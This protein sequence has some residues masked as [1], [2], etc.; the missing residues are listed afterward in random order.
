MDIIINSLYSKKEIFLREL[1]S[2]AADALDKIRFLSLANET[3]LGTG[4]QRDLEIRISAD[5][6]A[7]TMTIRDKGV[8]M[9]KAELIANLGTVAKSGTAAFMEQMSQGADVNL[10]GQFG[11]GFYSVYLVADRVRVASKAAGDVQY[12]WDS[13]ADGTFTIAPDAR[14]DTLGRGTEITLFLKEDATEY[15][16]PAD[17]K[18]LIKK[19][20]EFITF[21]IYLATTKEET[22]EVPIEEV[23]DA[24][25]SPTPKPS[26]DDEDE[27]VE[28]EDDE[29]DAKP[30]TKSETRSVTSWEVINDQK[31]LWQRKPKDIADADYVGFYRTVTKAVDEPIS[32]SHFTAEGEVEFRSILYIPGAAPAG[33][34]DNYYS[35]Q[36]SLRLYVRKVLISDE[37]EELLPRYLSFIKGIVDSDDLPLNVSRETLQQHKI[38]KIMGKKLVRKALEMIKK[39]ADDQRRAKKGADGEDDDSEVA[40][41]NEEPLREGAATAY[42]KFW[43]QFGK[44]IKMGIIEDSTNRSKL[45]KLLRFHSTK[46]GANGWRSL[47][48]YVADMAEGQKQIYYI[49]GESFAAVN[50]SAFLERLRAK[51]LEV[52]YLIDPIDEHAIQNLPE[53]ENFRL[54]S[55]TKEGLALP[56]DGALEKR[57]EEAYKEAFEPLVT[58]LKTVYGDKVGRVG[59]PVGVRA[60]AA[61]IISRKLGP[62]PRAHCYSSAGREGCHFEP[63][64]NVAVHPGHVAVRLLREHG[65]HHALTGLL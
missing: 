49:A 63:S 42:D 26:T 3:L 19:Y 31:A 53:F 24:D 65:A 52:L 45:A 7:K 41:S 28:A 61:M 60:A 56:G 30:K 12:V 55:I 27:A 44:S 8:G 39:L 2:N 47:D 25:A 48:D 33:M 18:T 21:P 23:E 20:S 57:R 32:W 13:T 37:F 9:T 6:K 54:Q 58:Y 38:L 1:I 40:K 43:E 16:N 29:A 15:S 59:R 4:E 64:L 5:D 34:W 22:V 11:V 17:L 50:S 36:S 10:I 35:K 14:G 46:T 62:P 51:D